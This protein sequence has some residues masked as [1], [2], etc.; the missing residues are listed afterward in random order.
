MSPGTRRS[1]ARRIA[2]GWLVAAA[3]VMQDGG[4]A[5]QPASPNPAS[6]VRALYQDHFAHEQRWDL[7]YQRQR[8]L[9]TPS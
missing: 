1:N 3:A 5:A 4:A 6:V 8:A 9:S 2:A 7:T